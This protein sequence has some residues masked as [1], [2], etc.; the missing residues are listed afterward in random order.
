MDNSLQNF[1]KCD[2]FTPDNISKLMSSYLNKNGNI[3]EPAVG[4]GQLLKYI[5]LEN[6]TIDIYDIK[7]MY[8]DKCPKHK[9]IINFNEDFIKKNFNKKYNNIIL[10]PPYIKIQDLSEEFRTY[11][12]ENWNILSKGN[13]DIYY[14]FILKCI[15][16]LE[17]DGIMISITPNS[18]LYNKSLLN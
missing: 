2:I 16:L 5:N 1:T 7:K 4:D 13:V 18:Y 9:N 10:N 14:A 3:L 6:Y 8:L 15:N 11:L 12:K 17:S